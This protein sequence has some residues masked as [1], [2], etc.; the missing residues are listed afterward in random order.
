M[1]RAQVAAGLEI[2]PYHPGDEAAVLE[3]LSLA[4]TRGPAGARSAEF[5]RW[6]HE[7]NPFGP[8][9]ILVATH[10]E[11]VVG[12][13][14]FMRWRLRSASATLAAVRAV[15]TATHPE[16]RRLGVF[17]RL[18]RRALE[19][20]GRSA[21]LVFNTPNEASLPGYL[22][23]GWEVVGRPR[24]SVRIRQPL[25]FLAGLRTVHSPG[26]ARRPLPA[27]EAEPA[28]EAL[29]ND[30]EVGDLLRRSSV[31]GA[32][33]ATPRDA[34][35][36]RWRY[37][38][39]PVLGYRA[40][41]ERGPDGL[42]GLAVI[43]VRPRGSLWETTVSELLV[44]P[45]DDGTARRLLRRVAGAAP[46]DHLAC[47]F[48]P[49]SAEAR[50]GARSGFVRTPLGPTLVVR[51]LGEGLSGAVRRLD[52]WRLTLGDLEVL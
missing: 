8:S 41:A 25:R 47:L 3:L 17:S 27:V 52:G 11:Q 34:A 48:P 12:L 32:E 30:E 9:F 15:D 49:G 40:V 10:G 35:Y 19:E 6:K 20:L 44:P 4:L 42:R 31:P 26:L 23:L 37:G 38:S 13:R 7:Q 2:R 51:P 21:D 46:S 28:A 33:L 14:A 1:T 39:A 24:V 50:A 36:L 18:T 29:R 43:R 22:K 16:W 45:G 5:F